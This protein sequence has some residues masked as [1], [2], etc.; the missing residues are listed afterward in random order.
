M[1]FP[2]SKGSPSPYTPYRATTTG[3][4]P[5]KGSPPTSSNPRPRG[6]AAGASSD[7]PGLTTT[8]ESRIDQMIEE[9]ARLQEAYGVWTGGQRRRRTSKVDAGRFVLITVD[10]GIL[11]RVDVEQWRWLRTT[12]TGERQVQDGD[13]WTP[14]LRSGA[15]PG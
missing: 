12:R 11:R 10:T 5:W 9:A 2:P 8:T 6:S 14:I 7:R 15:L 13:S 3:T 4:T 1:K